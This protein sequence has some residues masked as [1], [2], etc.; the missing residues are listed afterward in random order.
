MSLTEFTTHMG[1]RTFSTPHLRL[2]IRSA[3]RA[4]RPGFHLE[5]SS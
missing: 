5:R 4:G 1:Y 3:E 2:D